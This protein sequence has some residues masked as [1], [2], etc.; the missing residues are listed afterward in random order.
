MA[1]VA[2]L[3]VACEKED[4]INPSSVQVTEDSTS[5]LPNNFKSVSI[6]NKALGNGTGFCFDEDAAPTQDPCPEGEGTCLGEVVV[7]PNV[8]D[9]LSEAIADEDVPTFLTPS[10]IATLSAGSIVIEDKLLEVDNGTKKIIEVVMP[11]SIGSRKAFL[12]G[13]F[14]ITLNANN[15]DLA[16][17]YE[18]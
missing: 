9:G 7:T 3:F 11:N 10:N 2:M 18:I 17:V 6:K 1:V 8:V 14:A 5:E 16:I 15:C 4:N 12:I 13:D